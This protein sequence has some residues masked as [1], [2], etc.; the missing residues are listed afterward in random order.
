MNAK[1]S[2]SYLSHFLDSDSNVDLSFCCTLAVSVNL[3]FPKS[4][5][6][7]NNYHQFFKH[8]HLFILFLRR[9]LLVS[10]G[11]GCACRRN[12]ALF[13]KDFVF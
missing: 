13:L 11:S 12:P 4:F 3:D 5:E 6:K 1:I 8:S 9:S 7:E 10:G 2:C